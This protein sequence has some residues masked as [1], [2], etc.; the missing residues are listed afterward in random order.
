MSKGQQTKQAEG[1]VPQK[2]EIIHQT[3]KSQRVSYVEDIYKEECWEHEGI[4]KNIQYDCT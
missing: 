1:S 3:N 4:K 2:R